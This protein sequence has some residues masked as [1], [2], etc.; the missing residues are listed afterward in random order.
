VAAP[1]A[2][3]QG[4]ALLLTAGEELPAA[5]AAYLDTADAGAVLAV[6]GPAATAAPDAEQLVG[7]DRYTTAAA[8]AE[9]FFAGAHVAGVAS[10]SA[11]ADAATGGAHIAAMGGPLLLTPP[12]RVALRT[13]SAIGTA[14]ELEQLIVYGG[15]AVIPEPLLAAYDSAL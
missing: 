3:A 11:F 8:V 12:D 10:G 1:L 6:G 7:A 5:T 15:T 13:A 4:R 14:P 2:A 9:R